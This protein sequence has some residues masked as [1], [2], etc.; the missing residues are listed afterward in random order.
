[1]QGPPSLIDDVKRRALAQGLQLGNGYGSWKAGSL[2]IANFPA[3]P[4]AA[5]EQLVQFFAREFA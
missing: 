2:R 5:F 4:D 1:M 3:I